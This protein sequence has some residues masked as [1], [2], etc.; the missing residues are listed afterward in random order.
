MTDRP[1]TEELTR[2]LE[3]YDENGSAMEHDQAGTALRQ[4]GPE[5]AR[6]V[7]ELRA[8]VEALEAQ[9]LSDAESRLETARIAV[10]STPDMETGA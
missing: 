3:L 2:L 5:C 7:I 9:V 1:T 4:M 10:A 6:E 8:K